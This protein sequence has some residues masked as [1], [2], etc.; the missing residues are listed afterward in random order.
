VS[1]SATVRRRIC[2][3]L[4]T[5]RACTDA[6]RALHAEA[7]YGA[8]DFDVQVLILDSSDAR[9]N[10]AHRAV[11]E[12]LVPV[13]HV[14]VHLLDEKAQRVF[15]ESA[16]RASGLDEPGRLTE[17]MLPGGVSYGA[18]TNR[19]FLIAAALGCE[20]M[21]RRDS[22]S[23]YQ[24]LDGRPVFPIDQEL[25]GVGRRAGEV[26]ASGLVSESMLEPAQTDRTV[27]I[28]GASFIGETSV[29]ISEIEQ[30][31]NDVYHEV[32]SLWAPSGW[33]EEQRREL[34]SESFRGAGLTP[35]AQDHSVLGRVDP[36]RIDM[37]N[38]AFH[39]DAYERVPLLPALDTIGSD[40]FLMH[41][42]YDAGLPGI[43]HNRHI[44]NFYT[45]ERRT[46][47]GFAAYQLRFVKFFLSMLYLNFIYERMGDLGRALLDEQGR[48][49]SSAIVELAG[50]SA[51][52]DTAENRWRLKTIDRCYRRLGGRYAVF[53][54]SIALRGAGLIERARTDI[55]EFALLTEVWQ[56]L[57]HA[58]R[59]TAAALPPAAEWRTT[60]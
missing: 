34:V 33:T 36:M 48:L 2:L 22:D 58:A 30:L 49:R 18:C 38:I 1:V 47:A 40:Y 13:P 56:P 19:A 44:V 7:A 43:L 55:E 53:A 21:H 24:V 3:A 46:D 27:V 59:A 14:A 29:D 37:C 11:V 28:A 60:S 26:A 57:V 35:F 12:A 39:R 50:E 15:L 25:L 17:L 5:N 41:A 4:P 32:V 42:I 31:D 51:K 23:A 9:T 20:S 54:D 16:I 52:L 45:A 8:D 6:I 10:A